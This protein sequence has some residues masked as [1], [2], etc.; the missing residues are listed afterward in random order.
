[1]RITL[2]VLAFSKAISFHPPPNKAISSS[3]MSWLTYH[4]RELYCASLLTKCYNRD[5][6]TQ[7]TQSQRKQI[8]EIGG[9]SYVVKNLM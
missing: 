3:C 5:E 7:P 9:L 1:M 8:E 4:H 6:S 2:P